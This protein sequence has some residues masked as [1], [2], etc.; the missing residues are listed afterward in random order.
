MVALGGWAVML[1]AGASVPGSS[2]APP[3]PADA[4]PPSEECVGCP[5][6][7]GFFVRFTGNGLTGWY[8]D[9]LY[10]DAE[11][12]AISELAFG[13]GMAFGLQI[14]PTWSIAVFGDV[15]FG[16]VDTTSLE[17]FAQLADVD[18]LQASVGLSG[19]ITLGQDP[20]WQPVL[21]VEGALLRQW[22]W[23]QSAEGRPVAVLSP[24]TGRRVGT[25]YRPELE[26][27][28]QHDGWAVGPILGLAKRL[29]PDGYGPKFVVEAAGQY[30]RWS[31]GSTDVSAAPSREVLEATVRSIESIQQDAEVWSATIRVGLQFGP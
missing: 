12:R 28:S 23:W 21:G 2:E 9:P 31:P 15:L 24:Y 6:R 30:Q 25:V 27:R 8:G 26:L 7:S 4:G 14:D 19:R 17:G 5:P 3:P 13:A 20:G 22:V 1:L 11:R 10:A 18:S 29:G 16:G